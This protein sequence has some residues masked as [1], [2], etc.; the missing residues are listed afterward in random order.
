MYTALLIL[1]GLMAVALLGAITYEAVLM[2]R[3]H[4]ERSGS[5]VDRYTGIKKAFTVA[6]V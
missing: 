6:G 5:C 4:T 3:R 2:F 1:R